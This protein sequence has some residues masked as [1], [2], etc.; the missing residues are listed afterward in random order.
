MTPTLT[1][2]LVKTNLNIGSPSIC[3]HAWLFPNIKG[4]RGGI[5][6]GIILQFEFWGQ[7]FY[8]YKKALNFQNDVM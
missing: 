7:C 5:I 2:L 8:N 1:A 6:R 3:M 4:L